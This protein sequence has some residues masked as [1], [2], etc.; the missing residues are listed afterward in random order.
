MIKSTPQLQQA[1]EQIEPLY[2]GLD[3]LRADILSMNRPKR[4]KVLE[5]GSPLPLLDRVTGAKAAEGCR[6]P[7]RFRD[8]RRA[9]RFMVPMHARSE[10]KL[11]KNPRNFALFAE[12]PLD[13]IRKPQAEIDRYITRLEQVAAA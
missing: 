6:S 11:P 13:E 1:I 12:G 3:S 10:R 2:Q 7:R 5:C 8:H 9:N 4:R